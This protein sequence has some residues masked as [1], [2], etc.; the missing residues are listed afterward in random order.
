MS[1]WIKCKKCG[2]EFSS[3]L[4][5]CPECSKRH[6]NAKVYMLSIMGL[7]L[8][9]VVLLGIF[10]GFFDKSKE[11]D[12]NNN[13]AAEKEPI[14]TEESASQNASGENSP[15]QNGTSNEPSSSQGDGE[16]NAPTSSE[17]AINNSH[18]ETHYPIGTVVVDNCVYTTVPKFYLDY[19]YQNFGLSSSVTFEKFAYELSD[20]DRESG[21]TEIIRN[22]DGSATKVL[23]YSKITPVTADRLTNAFSYISHMV[24]ERSTTRT[25]LLDF[26]FSFC[27][28]SEMMHVQTTQMV[29]VQIR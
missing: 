1:K 7:A 26:E 14:S 17:A 3:A 18:T 13:A 24:L 28:K 27:L 4:S 10:M 15:E 5:H 29:H 11:N 19:I 21:Y 9:S 22:D 20:E 16:L 25:I 6:L 23:P 12:I 8:C 2:H